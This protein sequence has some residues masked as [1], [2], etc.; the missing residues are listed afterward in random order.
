LPWHT[1]SSTIPKGMMG[2]ASYGMLMASTDPSIPIAPL[3][4][5]ML[6]GLMLLACACRAS[7]Y[8]AYEHKSSTAIQCLGP[9]TA[10]RHPTHCGVHW[11]GTVYEEDLI[12]RYRPM[13]TCS[14]VG[15]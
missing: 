13:L 10:I 11:A 14:D 8:Q 1:G 4:S 7:S 5:L 15:A 12:Y 2:A 9:C 3:S 6:L